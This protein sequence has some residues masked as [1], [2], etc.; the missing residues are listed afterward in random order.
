M[1]PAANDERKSVGTGIHI[2]G[3]ASP[4]TN[5]SAMAVAMAIATVFESASRTRMDQETVQAAIQTLG[6]NLARAGVE[7]TNIS[8]SHFTGL[9]ERP[10]NIAS[11]PYYCGLTTS[12]DDEPTPAE[13]FR[14][15]Q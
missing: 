11:T 13:R 15:Y 5:E 8:G 9:N 14:S 1:F 7:G 6:Q 4:V 12:H 2:E 3:T 10:N